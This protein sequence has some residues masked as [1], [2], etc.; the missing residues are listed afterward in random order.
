VFGQLGGQSCAVTA[1]LPFLLPVVL[2]TLGLVQLPLTAATNQR[3]LP[4]VGALS[5][6]M[7]VNYRLTYASF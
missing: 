3:S 7:A 1:L 6:W 5:C 2:F 4:I